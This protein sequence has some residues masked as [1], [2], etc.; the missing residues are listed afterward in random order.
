MPFD[1]KLVNNLFRE[2]S[3]NVFNYSFSLLKNH[4][5]ADD[6]VQE[7]F[8]RLLKSKDSFKGN[9]SH[10]TWI[11]IITR[12]YCFTKL[13]GKGRL[14][15]RIDDNLQKTDNL[16]IETR[17][18]LDE[19]LGKLTAEEFELIFLREYEKYAYQEIAEII[20]TSVDNIKV[21]LFRVRQQL[22][23]YLQ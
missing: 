11:M 2:Y 21:K 19:A 9:C 6:A 23:K 15:E 10:K 8:M 14:P 12:N 13:N 20:G 7:V 22:K 5:D 17:I 4:D 3:E 18:S 1:D 16:S